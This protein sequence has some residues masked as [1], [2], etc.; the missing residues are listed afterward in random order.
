MGQASLPHAQALSVKGLKPAFSPHPRAQAVSVTGWWALNPQSGLLRA[1]HPTSRIS[2][3]AVGD[4]WHL[5]CSCDS[6][7]SET[8]PHLGQQDKGN[9]AWNVGE[10][11]PGWGW[12]GGG[13]SRCQPT[14]PDRMC[15]ARDMDG[16]GNQQI[17]TRFS[18]SLLHP[19]QSLTP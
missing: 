3:G 8:Q 19:S 18:L 5:E 2:P 1:W 9:E 13:L 16:P 17:L 4:Q 6:S 14:L 7:L 12:V 11:R 15:L 10:S